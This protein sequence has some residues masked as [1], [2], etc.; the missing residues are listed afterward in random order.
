VLIDNGTVSSGEAVAIAFQ[1]RPDTRFFNTAIC[2]R[3]TANMEYTLSDGAS[4]FLAEAIMADRMKF[5]YG[6]HITPDEEV[7]NPVEVEQRAVAWLQAPG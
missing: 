4:L 3:S 2:G 7:F 5:M 1:R 6:G